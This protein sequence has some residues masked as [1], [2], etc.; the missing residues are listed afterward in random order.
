MASAPY[1]VGEQRASAP[2]IVLPITSRGLEITDRVCWIVLAAAMGVAAA[3]ILYLNRG[4]VFFLD[5]LL[6]LYE[7]P[8]LA[9]PGEVLKPHEGHLIATTRLVFKAVLETVGLEY[10][11][12]RVIAVAAVLLSAGLF[13][14]LAKRRI[15]GLPALAPTLVLLFLGSAAQHV[16]IPVGFTI[17]FSVAAGLG[18]LLL[19]ERHDRRGDIGACLLLVVSVAT[20]TTGL[21][22]LVGVAVLVLLGP[23]RRRRLWVFLVPLALYAA[24]WLWS[25]SSDASAESEVT[26]SNILLIPNWVADSLASVIAALSGLGYDFTG[27]MP[28]VIHSGWGLVLAAPAT[29]AFALRVR[30]GAVSPSLWAFVAIALTYWALGALASGPYRSPDSIRYVYMGSMAVLLIGVAAVPPL[31][32]SRRGLAILFAVAALCLGGNLA[33]LRDGGNRFRDYSAGV[34]SQLAV[35][36]LARDRVDP[37]FDPPEASLVTA[38]AS[39]YFAVLDRYGS[40]AYSLAEL[41]RQDEVVREA[42][43]R[44]LVDELA[45]RLEASSSRPNGGCRQLSA[46]QAE[47]PAGFELPPGGARLRVRAPGPAALTLGRF[48]DLP[49]AELGSLSPRQ[50]ATLRIP[51]DASP[52]P[53]RAAVAGASS[54]EVCELR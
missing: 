36:E 39:A 40:A 37:D 18:S 25:L 46:V 41:Q 34:R 30:R 6:W 42:A 23:D 47:A 29:V 7:S 48:G 4:T 45:L 22:F 1:T 20:Y 44:G 54:V 52:T 12:F 32:L 11:V 13:Y 16:V 14:V 21:A 49:S 53:W 17:V 26:A 38:P 19:L 27:E 50:P 24:W 5:E 8:G 28:D 10:A 3:L 43:D 51:P 31:R 2:R 9:S 33:L 15:G 35:L